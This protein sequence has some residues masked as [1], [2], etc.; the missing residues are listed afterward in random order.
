MK[1]VYDSIKPEEL[2]KRRL[3]EFLKTIHLQFDFKDGRDAVA[4]PFLKI[5]KMIL[6]IYPYQKERQKI[7][8]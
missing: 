6:P 3:D 1:T 7:G 8:K 5:K 4:L 2:R